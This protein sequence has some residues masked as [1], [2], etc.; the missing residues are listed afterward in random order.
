MA[1][2]Q[3]TAFTP[4]A[5]RRPI[6]VVGAL[7]DTAAITRRN[8]TSLRRTPR[9]FVFTMIQPVIFVILFRYVFGGAISLTLIGVPYVYYLM[10]GI[11]VQTV[12]FGSITTGISMATDVQ[13]GI[14]ERFKSLPMARSGVLTGRTTA[15]LA[16]NILVVALIAGVGFAVGFRFQTNIWLFL[17]AL[18]LVVYWSYALSWV[19]TLVALWLKDPETTQAASFPII[20]PL[21]FASSAFVPVKTMPSWL[22]GFATYQPV[23]VTVSAARALCLGGPTASFLAQSLAWCTGIILVCAPLAVRYYRT[24]L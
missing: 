9:F 7:R 20:A 17:C 5:M 10:P 21:V 3:A 1:E 24:S 16:R 12:T 11:Y 4:E 19:F 23:S 6:P 15:D 8:L 14:L 22:Q 18:A 2:T 13:S